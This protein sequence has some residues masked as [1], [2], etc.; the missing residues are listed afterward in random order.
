[1][2]AQR[3]PQ[4]VLSPQEGEGEDRNNLVYHVCKEQFQLGKR[5]QFY[6][7]I[8]SYKLEIVLKGIFSFRFLSGCGV[9][10][11]ARHRQDGPLHAHR[12]LEEQ[13]EAA[14]AAGTP[15]QGELEGNKDISIKDA[16]IMG[17]CV[18][19]VA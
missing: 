17:G 15:P 12:A 2:Y 18:N 5:F 6:D 4:S 13:R 3:V 11:G 1:M 10:A 16:R 19:S 9:R 14:R 8:Y 7:N